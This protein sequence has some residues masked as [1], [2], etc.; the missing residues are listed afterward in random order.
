MHNHAHKSIDANLWENNSH[1]ETHLKSKLGAEKECLIGPYD[2]FTH[3]PSLYSSPVSHTVRLRCL[4]ILLKPAVWEFPFSAL[5]AT[6]KT[7]SA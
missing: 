2:S 3:S 1:L 7:L 6:K 5:L 4:P